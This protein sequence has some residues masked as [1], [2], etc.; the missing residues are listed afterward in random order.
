MTPRPAAV[1]TQSE[2][3]AAR[4]PSPSPPGFLH[5][6]ARRPDD[7]SAIASHAR[8]AADPRPPPPPPPPPPND[9]TLPHRPAPPSLFD[10]AG[11]GPPMDDDPE[12]HPRPSSYPY[13]ATAEWSFDVSDANPSRGGI[14]I[15]GPHSRPYYHTAGGGGIGIGGFGRT[16]RTTGMAGA[17][18]GGFGERNVRFQPEARLTHSRSQEEMRGEVPKGAK[19]DEG[20]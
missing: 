11:M 15:A 4:P 9:S 20:S 7:T 12:H 3:P 16:A 17:G 13:P 1:S 2:S 5:P 10:A 18:A 14:G 6:A 19:E 8:A